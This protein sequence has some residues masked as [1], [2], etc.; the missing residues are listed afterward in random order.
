V[1]DA[2]SWLFIAAVGFVAGQILSAVLLFIVAALNGHLSDLSTLAA[3]TVPPAWV[4]VGGLVGLWIGF[5]SAVVLASRIRGTGR[6]VA[7]MG[8]RVRRWDPVIGI[9]AGLVGQLVLVNLLYLPFE[10]FNP[11]LS[12]ELQAPAKHLTGGFPGID[13]AVIAALTVLVVPVI[14][15]LFFRGLVLGGFLR[16]FR[17]AGRLLGPALAVTTTGIVFGLAHVELIELLG[18]AAFGIVLSLMAYKFKRLGP[19]IF[20]HAT[21]NLIAILSIAFQGS[22]FLPARWLL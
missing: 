1:G 3:L 11:N 7:D 9:V 19:S 18:L 2:T 22:V 13:L 6:V 10:H 17:G 15:E 20:G 14:E 12:R 4:V 8:L 21:F 5:L 16:L